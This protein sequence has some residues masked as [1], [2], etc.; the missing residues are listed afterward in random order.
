MVQSVGYYRF[1]PSSVR[2]A[3]GTNNHTYWHLG[4]I[5]AE[6]TCDVMSGIGLLFP[7]EV[8][9]ILVG[10]QWTG[11]KGQTKLIQVIIGEK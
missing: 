10:Q 11:S 3:R 1:L 5:S 6:D 8:L 9:S 4:E 7:V 2:L